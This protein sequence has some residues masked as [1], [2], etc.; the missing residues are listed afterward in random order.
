MNGRLRI[1]TQRVSNGSSAGFT[2]VE[3]LVVI[4]IIGVLAAIGMAVGGK[5][6]GSSR[7][8]L[9]S[10]A[11]SILDLSLS[12]FSSETGKS[13]EPAFRD[14]RDSATNAFNTSP[15]YMVAADAI[16]IDGEPVILNSVGLYMVQVSKEPAAQAIFQNLDSKL[17]KSFDADSL[18]ARVASS[19]MDPLTV[20]PGQWTDQPGMP[21]VMDAWGRP[22]RYVHPAF[23]GLFAE[24]DTQV[25]L[26]G[27]VRNYSYTRL[28]RENL[29]TQ[30]DSDG[31]YCVGNRPYFYSAGP[32]GDPTTVE[33]NVYT[34]EPRFE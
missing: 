22:M 4:A 18:D 13:P 30:L 27:A 32:D 19:N 15:R 26:G 31:G 2:L 20:E 29:P 8:S 16:N 6:I 9:T 34:T 24:E 28:R 21:T 25:L 5:V 14:P 10:R 33:D 12:E 11:I 17:I 3:L 7:S 1:N 23:D